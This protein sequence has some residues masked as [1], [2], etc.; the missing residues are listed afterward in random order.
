MLRHEMIQ[1]ELRKVRKKFCIL[2]LLTY[3]KSNKPDVA[4]A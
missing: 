3:T 4:V 1:V 2:S